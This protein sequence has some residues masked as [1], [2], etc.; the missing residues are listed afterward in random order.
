MTSA[1]RS[2]GLVGSTP[3][4][5]G[6]GHVPAPTFNH[7]SRDYGVYEDGTVIPVLGWDDGGPAHMLNILY[8]S[9]RLPYTTNALNFNSDVGWTVNQSGTIP[10]RFWFGDHVGLY[11]YHVDDEGLV[12][13]YRDS[14]GLARLV[15]TSGK[16]RMRTVTGDVLMDITFGPG[17]FDPLGQVTQVNLDEHPDL[18]K[19][20]AVNEQ[21]VPTAFTR[22]L[23]GEDGFDQAVIDHAGSDIVVD[24]EFP[25]QLGGFTFPGQFTNGIPAGVYDPPTLA[26]GDY[27]TQ[28]SRVSRTGPCPNLNAVV[29]HTSETPSTGPAYSARAKFDGVT[30]LYRYL[31]RA[32]A[33]YNYICGIKDTGQTTDDDLTVLSDPLYVV[34]DLIDPT[35]NRAAHAGYARGTT[36]GSGNDFIGLGIACLARNFD[37]SL[38]LPSYV[39]SGDPADITFNTTTR[40]A[41]RSVVAAQLLRI[42]AATGTTIARR[43]AT[44]FDDMKA[45]GGIIGHGELEP[46]RKNDPG[47]EDA[48]YD[49]VIAI[50]EAADEL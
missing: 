4:E 3:T 31:K 15:T 8:G 25:I 48:D 12:V 16:I 19:V 29:I 13:S 26:V 30:R 17:Q 36:A 10:H 28:G 32:S 6:D 24:F 50:L 49:A 27:L 20:I 43:H 14:P 7:G 35:L 46:N 39:P 40:A 18:Y 45:N 38:P 11:M 37:A 42:E 2:F 23:H 47:W 5:D 41:Y 1:T 21:G 44:S 34:G 33:G 22:Y 9:F